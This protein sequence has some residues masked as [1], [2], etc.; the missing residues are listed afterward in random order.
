MV[1]DFLGAYAAGIRNILIITGDPPKMGT[2]PDASAV[3]DVD[4]IGLTRVASILNH[5]RDLGGNVLKKATGFF[6]GVG[7]NP[8]AINLEQEIRRL[9][10]K[11]D[12]GAEYI[13]TQPVFDPEIFLTFMDRIRHIKLPVIAGIWPLV[14]VRNAEFMNNEVPGAHV[15]DWVMERLKRTRSKEEARETGLTIAR[16]TLKILKPRIQ[17]AQISMPF[18]NVKY[19][20]EVLK[21]VLS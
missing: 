8:G 4:S 15:P 7:A 21:E 1:G 5:G 20:L 2:F 13:M 6:I 17:G 11:R 19:P 9:E 16:E 10:E 18:G 12:A 3:F 14:S